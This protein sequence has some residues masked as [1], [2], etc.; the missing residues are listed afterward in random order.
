M[1]FIYLSLVML[2]QLCPGRF[3][4][5]ARRQCWQWMSKIR[6]TAEA[7]GTQDTAAAE[8]GMN[9]GPDDPGAH[10]PLETQSHFSDESRGGQALPQKLSAS[11]VTQQPASGNAARCAA[12]LSIVDPCRIRTAYVHA[13]SLFSDVTPVLVELLRHHQ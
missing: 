5:A 12:L 10:S 4:T 9:V 11:R 3:W 13:A 1:V 8:L 2:C 6:V 7:T